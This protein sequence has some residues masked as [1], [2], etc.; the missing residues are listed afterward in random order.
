MCVWTHLCGL[1][2]PPPHLRQQTNIFMTNFQNIETK[3]YQPYNRAII[4]LTYTDWLFHLVLNGKW[5][6]NKSFYTLSRRNPVW[7]VCV[8]VYARRPIYTR[9]LVCVL[10]R[11]FQ[12]SNQYEWRFRLLTHATSASFRRPDLNRIY[13]SFHSFTLY[14]IFSLYLTR[15]D[16]SF[17]DTLQ[18]H[19][20][21][22]WSHK[23][24]W[25]LWIS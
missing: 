18:R 6:A 11:N 17:T 14:L 1:T 24:N 2:Q 8:C 10:L 22:N 7:F 21:I 4:N 23:S 19:F 13:F 12:V 9:R 15:S 20:L 16:L 5:I 3:R 25:N